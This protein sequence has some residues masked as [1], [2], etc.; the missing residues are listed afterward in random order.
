MPYEFHSR[1][2]EAKYEVQAAIQT[3][4][5]QVFL[6]EIV[7]EAV[8]TS[9]VTPEGLAYNIRK[10]EEKKHKP[11]TKF[12]RHD[13]AANRRSIAVD[14]ILKAGQVVAT[15]FTASG[16]GGWLEVG[17]RKMRAQPYLWPAFLKF[18]DQ[19]PV[20]MKLEDMFKR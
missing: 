1:V 8:R 18:K 13:T 12:K 3:A 10:F 19:I 2:P 4:V 9:P 17:T 14:V 6:T 15:L 16:H 20:R 7:P 5:T 11:G